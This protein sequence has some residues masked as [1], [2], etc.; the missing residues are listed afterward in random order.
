MLDVGCSMFPN[1]AFQIHQ[2]AVANLVWPDP[3]GRVGGVWSNNIS[4]GTWATIAEN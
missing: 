2:V 4:I 1:E 3:R